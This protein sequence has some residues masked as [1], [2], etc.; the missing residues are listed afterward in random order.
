MTIIRA[1]I[2]FT[3]GLRDGLCVDS[4]DFLRHDSDSSDFLRRNS[5]SLDFLRHDSDSLDFLRHNSDSLDF[6]RHNSDVIFSYARFFFLLS[7]KVKI[8]LVLAT[9]IS[10]CN[11]LLFNTAGQKKGEEKKTKVG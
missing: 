1:K 5:D 4:L 6:L 7:L 9:E 2:Y 3:K 10:L 11:K 8:P